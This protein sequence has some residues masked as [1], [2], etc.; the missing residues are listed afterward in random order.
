MF[1]IYEE[2]KKIPCKP[3]IYMM[4]DEN[5]DIIYV[6]K[7]VILKNRVRQY[8][9]KSLKHSDKVIAMVSHVKSF[10][11]II[12]DSELEAL[13][14]ECNLIKQYRPKFNV[15][16]KDDKNYPYI[17]VTV[18]EEY[19]RVLVTR[20]MIK[21]G[22]VY[23]GPYSSSKAV[24]NVMDIIREYF[25]TKKCNKKLNKKT[26]ECLNYHIG[27]CKGPCV[28]A[29]SKDDYRT[30]IDEICEFLNG[31]K[32][33][34]KR[35]LKKMMEQEAEAL[36]F[37]KAAKL[38]DTIEGLEH[39]GQEQKV[40]DTKLKD[41]DV[42]GFYRNDNDVCVQI[43]YI[44]EG[45][46]IGRDN[47]V[48]SE[49]RDETD[50]Q[51]IDAF[52]CQF[53]TN[54]KYI[55]S[56]I[57]I[58]VELGKKDILGDMLTNIKKSRVRLI[59]PQR[60]EN[61]QLVNFVNRNAKQEMERRY[62]GD[63]DGSVKLLQEM[64]GI[65]NA[66]RRIESY[67]VSNI[68]NENIVVAMVVVTDGKFDKGQYRKFKIKTAKEQND[69]QSMQEAV[70]RR[71]L[72]GIEKDEKFSPLPDV[73]LVDGGVGHV[74]AVEE[75][76]K[77]LGLNIPLVGMVK[78][79]RHRTRGL[80][81]HDEEIDLEGEEGLFRFITQIQDETHR[82]ALGYNK[83]LRKRG[84]NHSSLDNISGIGKAKKMELLRYFK[85][86]SRIKEASVEEIAKV[87]GISAALARN[88]YEYYRKNKKEE[89]N[90]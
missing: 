42:I 36:N 31:N 18:G 59:K 82:C 15:L 87:P 17:K 51:V 21:D 28:G 37:E 70:Y 77:E 44:R 4:K 75:V 50:E 47:Y 83:K 80:V 72:R 60:G 66:V 68:G 69:Y 35:E 39:L 65:D 24:N 34:L 33:A 56:N 26:R 8:F 57:Y 43:F 71:L 52:V 88:I 58:P 49:V 48:M 22:S 2:L 86:V 38:R 6:G 76:T 45:K 3:G 29:I 54:N 40:L 78:D 16:L 90:K 46:V 20:N 67:D 32:N 23:Y 14:L 81:V 7:A 13:I 62:G 84:Y 89:D 1:D 10:E 11:Y 85:G 41:K 64:I 25:P 53:Y 79:D 5:G 73:I 12:T 63:R 61:L 27:K 55:P 9:N 19:P 74:H 30:M